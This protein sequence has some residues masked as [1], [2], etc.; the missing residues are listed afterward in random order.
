MDLA[1]G[2]VLVGIIAAA[3]YGLRSI[4]AFAMLSPMIVAIFIGLLFGNVVGFPEK[5]GAGV[6]MA[7]KR[8]LRISVALLGLQ[9]T[10]SGLLEVGLVGMMLVVVAVSTTFA[11]TVWLGDAMGVDRGLSHL[12]ASGTAVC[13]ASA[14]AATN[15][16]VKAT[17][18]DVSY[19]IACVTLFGTAVMFI[20]P[21]L[22]P[23]LDLDPYAFGLWAGVSIHEVAQVVGAGFQGG[24]AA[25]QTSVVTKLARVL[26]LAPLLMAI[27]TMPMLRAGV[28]EGSK[29]LRLLTAVPAFVVMFVLLAAANSL[30]LIP[31]PVRS[32]LVS[33]T[34]I[35]LTTALAA[36]GL[37][38]SFAHLKTRGW[39]PMLL[40]LAASVFISVT[41]LA[42]VSV[43]VVQ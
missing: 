1:P 40:G 38:T 5:A 29:S 32:G 10:F 17:R 21:L 11:F 30:G 31:D 25:G 13:G 28:P 12:I 41:T 8:L 14:I 36:L 18:E 24:E 27:S 6:A 33:V 39:R 43:L 23:V 20:Y 7:G 22:L 19:A 15:A 3:A 4:Q 2:V 34:P 26:M 16:I 37:G 35:L 9:L 42:M